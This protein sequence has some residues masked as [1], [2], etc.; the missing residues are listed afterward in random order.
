MG[1]IKCMLVVFKQYPRV[2]QNQFPKSKF[3]NIP[4]LNYYFLNVLLL[5][6]VYKLNAQVMLANILIRCAANSE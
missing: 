3:I 4:N 5:Y 1:P 6:N 2:P